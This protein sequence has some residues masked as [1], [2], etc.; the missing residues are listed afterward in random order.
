MKLIFGTSNRGKLREASD[1]LGPDYQVVCPADLG[2]TE[3]VEETGETLE[4]NSILKAEHIF[5]IAH[6]AC[7]ADDT[8]LEVDAL[9]GAPGVRSA[10][11]AG[12]QHD[13]AANRR[14]LLEVMKDV[15]DELR[16]ARFRCVVTLILEDGQKHFFNGVVEGRIARYETGTNG[17][18]YDAVFIPDAFPRY[19]MAELSDELKNSISHRGM[20]LR[21]MA[22]WLKDNL[23]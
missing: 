15:P 6:A 17:F 5:N 21:L 4:A 3:D 1:I 13:F 19:S 7:F 18:G 10:R 11:F 2:I 9:G 8:G 23:K 16:T 22:S 12:D 20:S 14:K